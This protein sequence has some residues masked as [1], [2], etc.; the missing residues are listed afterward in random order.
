[1]EGVGGF[2]NN[3]R[4]CSKTKSCERE[5]GCCGG[6]ETNNS[7]AHWVNNLLYLSLPCHGGFIILTNM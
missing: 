2:E 3:R 6:Y 7:V 5:I 1:M 4:C